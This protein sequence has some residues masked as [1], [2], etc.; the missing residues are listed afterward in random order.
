[1]FLCKDMDTP[2][3]DSRTAAPYRDPEAALGERSRGG[4]QSCSSGVDAGCRSQLCQHGIVGLVAASQT[5][6]R[7]SSARQSGDNKA[8]ACCDCV[9]AGVESGYRHV[10]WSDRR[11]GRRSAR[12]PKHFKDMSI[13]VGTMELSSH[14]PTLR[15]CGSRAII[16]DRQPNLGKGT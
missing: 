8:S 1:M 3:G 6:T 5:G 10:A 7:T 15:L 12:Q 9:C 11:V 13:A 14:K 2:L 4:R 16:F